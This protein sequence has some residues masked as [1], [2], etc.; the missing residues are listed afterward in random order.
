VIIE[1]AMGQDSAWMLAALP[2]LLFLVL[3]CGVPGFGLLAYFVAT[4]PRWPKADMI[5]R[6]AS[7]LNSKSSRR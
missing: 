4:G 2:A 1:V 3:F 6:I 7:R 5:D